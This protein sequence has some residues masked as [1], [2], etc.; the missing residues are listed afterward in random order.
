MSNPFGACHSCHLILPGLNLRTSRSHLLECGH[1]LCNRCGCTS[2]TSCGKVLCRSCN[3]LSDCFVLPTFRS[4]D[5]FAVKETRVPGRRCSSH[6][7]LHTIKCKCG[8]VEEALSNEMKRIK[9]LNKGLM[10]RKSELA[11]EKSRIALHIAAANKE[12]ANKFTIIIAQA[13]SRCLDLMTQTTKVGRAG[14]EAL[15]GQINSIDRSLEKIRQTM[16]FS[17]LRSYDCEESGDRNEQTA[18]RGKGK[19]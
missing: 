13:I 3:S 4:S 11:H 2:V 19:R 1:V 5:A 8:T 15:D 14:L 9:E 6:H 18:E 10:E 12:I 17:S 7:A 16:N